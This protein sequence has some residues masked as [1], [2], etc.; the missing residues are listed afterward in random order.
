[1]ETDEKK[2]GLLQ[3]YSLHGWLYTVQY[4]LYLGAEVAA[5]LQE[6]QKIDGYDGV[7]H[8]CVLGPVGRVRHQVHQGHVVQGLVGLTRPQQRVQGFLLLQ[9]LLH[10]K[11]P[12]QNITLKQ[13]CGSGSGSESGSV[14]SVCFSGLLD[15]YPDPSIIMQKSKKNLDTYCFMTLFDFLSLKN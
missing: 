2:S 9:Q 3:K 15:P 5:V 6:A 1:V 12:R 10:T 13:R 11:Y 4:V 8:L 7:A 14:G